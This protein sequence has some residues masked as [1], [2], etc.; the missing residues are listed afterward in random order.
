MPSHLVLQL[1]IYALTIGGSIIE[2]LTS[3][4]TCLDFTKQAKLLFIQDKQSS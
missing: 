2:Q 3:C 4:L 1:N